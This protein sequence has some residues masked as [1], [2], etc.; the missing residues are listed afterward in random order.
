MQPAGS[1]LQRCGRGLSYGLALLRRLIRTKLVDFLTYHL[2]LVFVKKADLGLFT[3]V[4]ASRE[5]LYAINRETHLKLA[6]GQFFGLTVR[7]SSLFCFQAHDFVSSRSNR[8][9]IIEISMA[10]GFLFSAK[11]RS[12]GFDNGCHQIDFIGEDLFV[13]DTYN[14]RILKLDR[15]FRIREFLFPIS[16]APRDA[17]DEGYAHLNSIVCHEGEIFLLKSNGGLKTGRL[18]EVLRCDS[19]LH[20]KETFTLPGLLCHNLVFLEDGTLLSCGSAEGTIVSREGVVA[21]IGEMM[22]RGLSIDFDVLVVGDSFFATRHQRRYV[23]G[24][25]FFYDRSYRLL[26]R[27]RL[28][29]APTEIRR[30]DGRDLSLS[31]YRLQQSTISLGTPLRDR[32]PEGGIYG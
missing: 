5:G 15:D 17:W 23:P 31:N 32:V 20:V 26:A 13:V 19:E 22:T 3:H 14:Q 24:S 1:I 4:V 11:V 25:V 27:Q 6:D 30:I 8:G 28:P 18:S 16:P 21:R 29:A 9:R 7:G 10:D 12:K 2:D